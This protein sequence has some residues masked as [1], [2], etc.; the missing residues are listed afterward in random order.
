MDKKY[1]Y[2]CNVP[3]YDPQWLH[4]HS[5]TTQTQWKWHKTFQLFILGQNDNYHYLQIQMQNSAYKHMIDTF[6]H[7]FVSFTQNSSLF[8]LHDSLIVSV[9]HPFHNTFSAYLCWEN[10]SNRHMDTLQD[11]QALVPQAKRTTLQQHTANTSDFIGSTTGL[12]FPPDREHKQTA[13]TTKSPF[14]NRE[15]KKQPPQ[16][17][18]QHQIHRKIWGTP[19]G[20]QTHQHHTHCKHTARKCFFTKPNKNGNTSS[21]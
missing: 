5:N 7:T 4:V 20:I 17:D 18:R 12:F 10:R 1:N 3:Q 15:P 2:H 19:K 14:N 6:T 8:S 9:N 11:S 21:F 13:P 16:Q